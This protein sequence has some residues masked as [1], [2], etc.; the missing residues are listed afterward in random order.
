VFP[1]AIV[2]KL[3]SHAERGTGR[4]GTPG[5]EMSQKALAA[6]LF[7][8]IS[9]FVIVGITGIIFMAARKAVHK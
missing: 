4:A 5:D 8:T 9:M 6:R 3:R 1:A 7:L 2:Q